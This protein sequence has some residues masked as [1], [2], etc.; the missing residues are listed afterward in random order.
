MSDSHGVFKI[1]PVVEDYRVVL[2]PGESEYAEEVLELAKN[3]GR[4]VD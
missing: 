2:V 1:T 4:A 3:L